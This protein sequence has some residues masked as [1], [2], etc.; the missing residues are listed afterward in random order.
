[1]RILV[2][3][4]NPDYIDSFI[5]A[6]ADEF[7]LGF[8]DSKWCEQYGSFEEINRMSSFGERANFSSP[9][10]ALS[11]ARRIKQSGKKCFLALNSA[12]YSSQQTEFL[13][14]HI[15]A[16]RD[17]GTGFIVGDIGLAQQCIEL[18]AD[19]TLS[20]MAGIYNSASVRAVQNLGVKRIIIPRDVSSDDIGRIIRE[21]PSVETEAFLMRNGC[22]FSDSNCMAF[23]ARKF[24]S[25]CHMLD[26]SKSTYETTSDSFEERHDFTLNDMVYRNIFHKKACGICAIYRLLKMGVFAVKLVGRADNCH[27]FVRE[28]AL[29]KQNIS[30]AEACNDEQEYLKKVIIPQ[31]YINLCMSGLN[32]YYPEVRF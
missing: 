29:I 19:I 7:Y 24:D 6:G 25:L 11:A 32:C 31:E 20:T 12:M 3:L 14:H 5:S 18:G 13:R 28:I 15:L 17:I 27:E 23:H 21:C 8:C 4:T 9:E 16:F 30:I 26:F 2:P 22:R 10:K 1:M